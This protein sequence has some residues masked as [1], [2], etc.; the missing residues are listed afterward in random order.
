MSDAE[1]C[2]GVVAVIGAPNAGKSTLV[3]RLTGSKVTIVSHK[4][5]TTRMRVR[6]VMMRGNAQVA[7]VDTP[8]IFQAKRSFDR[9]MVDAAW[10]GAGDADA[11]VLLVDAPAESAKPDGISARDTAAIMKR[12]KTGTR[13]PMALALN[14]VDAMQPPPLLAM[15]EAMNAE[16]AFDKTF[17]IS[18]EKGRGTE[19][20]AAWIAAQAKPGPWHFPEDQAGDLSSRLLAAEITREK[21]FL[22]L[23]DELPYAIHVTTEAWT[24]QKDGSVRIDQ[25]I[26]V[27]R[28]A[29]KPIVLGKGGT[30]V[31]AIGAASRKELEEIFGHRVHLFLHVKVQGGW[32]MD[33]R[34]FAELGLEPPE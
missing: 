3:N 10:A 12:L 2:F 18:A 23:H 6:G 13:A 22:R 9:A 16:L 31:K 7:L 32:A 29:H 30:T 26:L 19:E 5:Q 11:I 8:G 27:E 33:R 1:K 4:V 17:M 25:T 28:E 21:V 34:V 14:K 20:L 15:A 24:P